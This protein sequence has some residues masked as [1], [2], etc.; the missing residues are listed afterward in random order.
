MF[1]DASLKD[2]VRAAEE[3]TGALRPRLRAL[4]Q[5]LLAVGRELSF[6]LILMLALAILCAPVGIGIAIAWL[7]WMGAIAATGSKVLGGIAG[8][9]VVA[10]FARYVWGS[11]LQGA[12]RQAVAALLVARGSP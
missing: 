3:R 6:I 9:L 1:E 5:T 8:F 7:V 4:D 2:A 10:F 11:R 12:A